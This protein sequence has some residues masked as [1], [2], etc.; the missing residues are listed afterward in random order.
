MGHGFI[1]GLEEERRGVGLG[2]RFRSE[3]PAPERNEL[4][5]AW[6]SWEAKAKP[7]Y[8]LLLGGGPPKFSGQLRCRA[9]GQAA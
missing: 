3:A 5:A 6:S 2:W 1:L 9:A 8:Q 7:G 4:E